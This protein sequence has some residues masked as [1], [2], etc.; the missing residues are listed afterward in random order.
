MVINMTDC[1]RA[2]SN[3]VFN[4]KFSDLDEKTIEN[5]RIYIADYMAASHAGYKVNAAFNKSMLE[6]VDAMDGGDEAS[7]L[8]NSKKMSVENAAFMNAV[9]AHGADMDDGNRKARGHVAASVMSA[10]FAVAETMDVSWEDVFVA[11]NAGYDIYN[12]T[13][14]AVQ[15]DLVHRGFHS[16]GTAGAIACGGA[17]AKLMGLSEDKIYSAMGISAIQASG[18]III[19]ESGQACKPLN[20]ANAAKTGIIS[21][22]LAAKGVAGP[23]NFLES[24]KGWFH[25]MADNIDEAAIL[26]GLGKEFTINESYLKP[27]PSCRHTHCGIEA[28]MKLR[29]KLAAEGRSLDEIDKINVNIYN[30]AI[31]IAGIIEI[32]ANPDDAK[33]SIHYSLAV[34]LQKGNYTLKDL[35]EPVSDM[36]RRLVE[37]IHLIPDSSMEDTKAGIRGSAVE[38]ILADGSSCK[39]TVLLPKGDAANPFSWED[40]LL[41][42]EACLEDIEAAGTASAMVEKI[43]GLNLIEAYSYLA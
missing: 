22:K 5:T 23:V 18:L 8:L 43:R 41:K 31:Q 24:K 12:R 2:L 1:G 9:Y 37:K 40:M 27:Y 42:A 29:A 39:E 38:I 14:A 19:A 21:A 25:A 28:V 11:I 6:I 32:P 34:A 3:F 7:V 13:A 17:V 35:E 33:F 26:D 4:L 15:P 30:D 20:P 16:T 10:V 36:S